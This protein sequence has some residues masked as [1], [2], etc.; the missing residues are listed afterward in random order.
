MDSSFEFTEAK[1]MITSHDLLDKF[2]KGKTFMVIMDFICV[3]QK[4]IEGKTRK[5]TSFPEVNLIIG[6]FILMIRIIS[7]LKTCLKS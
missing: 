6:R 5:D 2:V 4:S 1:K 3:L 7:A